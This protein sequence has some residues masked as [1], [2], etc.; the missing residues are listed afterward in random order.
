MAFHPSE[1]VA[2]SCVRTAWPGHCVTRR[3]GRI[4]ALNRAEANG[5]PIAAVHSHN[6]NPDENGYIPSPWDMQWSEDKG[7]PVVVVAEGPT[8]TCY[9]VFDPE[10]GKGEGF[11]Q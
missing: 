5:E 3:P 10:A 7:L 11:C 9:N 2:P 6:N 1:R 8:Q 4:L